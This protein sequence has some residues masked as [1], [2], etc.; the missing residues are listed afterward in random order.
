M[1]SKTSLLDRELQRYSFGA[2]TR[3]PKGPR[4]KQAAKWSG[5]AAAAGASMAAA[6]VAEAA[7]VHVNPVDFSISIDTSSGSQAYHQLDL[8]GDGVDDFELGLYRFL[9]FSI[10]SSTTSS[11]SS[12]FTTSYFGTGSAT[13]RG[14]QMG[15]GVLANGSNRVQQLSSGATIG[16]GGNFQE[17]G[18]IRTASTYSFSNTNVIGTWAPGVDGFAG[19]QFRIGGQTHFGWIRLQ[20]DVGAVTELPNRLTVRDWAYES[21]PDTAIAA[22]GI[23]EPS[24]GGLACLAAG[25][26]G[27]GALRRRKKNGQR[28]DRGTP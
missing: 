21:S 26:A 24:T 28:V 20:M 4:R 13:M 3:L 23:P 19:L 8:N 10:T 12:T 2:A 16:P 9:G 1:S 18:R 17:L 5:F 14:L 22:G 7:P 6:H 11:G 27:V 25:A 15:N